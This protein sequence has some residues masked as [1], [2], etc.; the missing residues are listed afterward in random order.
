MAVFLSITL[1]SPVDLTVIVHILEDQVAR[2]SGLPMRI[3]CN[4]SGIF[5]NTYYLVS[6]TV[7]SLGCL[8]FSDIQGILPGV[9]IIENNLVFCETAVYERL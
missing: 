6:A 5:E 3:C 9:I 8:L 2:L 7:R 1:S 4:S